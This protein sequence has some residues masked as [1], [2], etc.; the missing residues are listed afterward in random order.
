MAGA[1]GSGVAARAALALV[2]AVAGAAAWF[3]ADRLPDILTDPQAYLFVTALTGGYL[4]VLLA[5]AGPLRL[6]AAAAAAAGPA[7]AAA[8]LLT[9]A[10]LR[11]DTL[12]GVLARTETL[13]AWFVVLALPLPFLIGAL[14]P[15]AIWRH[16]PTLFSESWGIVVRL[17]SAAAFAGIVWLVIFLSDELL[18]LVGI[19]LIGD[20]VG[21]A[22]VPSTLTG[23]V[24]GLALAILGEVTDGG[25]PGL[26]LRLLRLLIPPALLV[27]GLF[28]AAVPVQGLETLFGALS[29]TATLLGIGVFLTLLVSS[30]VDASDATAVRSGAMRW[31]ARALALLL[32]VVAGL[33]LGA[34]RLRIGAEGLSPARL[35]AALAGGVL[36]AYG[37][38]Y[39]LAVLS[40][41]RWMARIR[42]A[43]IAMALVVLL[44]AAAWL[45][46][47]VAPERLSARDQLARFADGRV[48]VEA[49]DLWTL[50]HGW[51][52]PGRA[53]FDA[54]AA[55]AP[56]HPEAARLA[57]RLRLAETAPDRFAFAEIPASPAI[58][59]ARAALRA[60]MPVVPAAAAAE[61]D[62]Y[63]LPWYAGSVTSFLEGCRDT[64]AGGRPGCVL[65]V[66]D[67]LP[68][69]PGRE[70]ILFYKSFG[71]LRGEVIV[72]EPVFR[73][74][75]ASEVFSVPPPDFDET[76]RLIEALQ[77][78]AFTTGPARINAIDIGDRQFTLPF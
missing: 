46:P 67:L 63:V 37:V 16:Y 50:R 22:W 33:A 73:R 40:G 32:P 39:A 70:A 72:P 62:R 36:L 49:L 24:A 77:D 26:V 47:L 41:P 43:N 15:G 11:Y 30:G 64:T 59:G 55:A 12:A 66:H 52:R 34:L 60:E 8:A 10:S 42:A 7:L 71:L 76:D 13:L 27:V 38:L 48:T 28:A 51:G 14:R 53:A 74:A 25:P 3:M 6:G 45:T 54:I 1:E 69:N 56:D 29:P 17:A 31:A 2:G 58:V 35:A 68:D 18:R 23:L 78:G 75:E 57:E 65:V 5:L 21:V 9:W 4:G 20:L 19:D 44:L 61:F